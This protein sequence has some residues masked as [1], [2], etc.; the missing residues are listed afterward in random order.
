M[1]TEFLSQNLLTKIGM[2]KKKKW[3][4]KTAQNYINKAAQKKKKKT[5]EIKSL[6]IWNMKYETLG[7]VE[8]KRSQTN[9]CTLN[10]LKNKGN[11]F[12]PYFFFWYYLRNKVK[13]KKIGERKCWQR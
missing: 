13:V 8:K 10:F 11:F 6:N 4:M 1:I 7:G 12:N 2:K 5:W 9:W 3:M